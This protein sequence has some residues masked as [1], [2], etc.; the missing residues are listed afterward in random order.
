MVNY[1][2]QVTDISIHG[3]SLTIF[4]LW[5]SISIFLY[6]IITPSKT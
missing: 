4:A 3:D 2:L 6:P 5:L 1:T